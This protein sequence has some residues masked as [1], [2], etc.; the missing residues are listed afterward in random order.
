M[1]AKR[2][3]IFLADPTL[4]FLKIIGGRH[5]GDEELSLSSSVN[6][7][8]QFGLLIVEKTKLNLTAGELLFCCDIL[9]GGAPLTLF[10]TP[11][12]VSIASAFESMTF[13]LKDAA[14]ENYGGEVEKWEILADDFIEKISFMTEDELFTLAI[15]T[16]QFW[17]QVE[18][19]GFKT[20][21]KLG[22][23]EAW[24]KQWIKT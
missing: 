3:P 21:S 7:A 10:Q 8:V 22:I 4:N 13:G 24:A 9:N 6:L 12:S 11:D 19:S 18:F 15:A 17:H 5:L 16:R 23:H 20:V 14:Y 2:L 1:T